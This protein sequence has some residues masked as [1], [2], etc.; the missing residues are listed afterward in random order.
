MAEPSSTPQDWKT[1]FLGVFFSIIMLLAGVVIAGNRADI[2]D[3]KRDRQDIAKNA[4]DAAIAATRLDATVSSLVAQ[5]NGLSR[6]VDGLDESQQITIRKLDGLVLV[7]SQNT[8]TYRD[9]V[10]RWND[11]IN[12]KRD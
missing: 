1:Y 2:A 8:K 6:R 3:L 5:V 10:T 12:R 7:I 9:A 11:E 4:M